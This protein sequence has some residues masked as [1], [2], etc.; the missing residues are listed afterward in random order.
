MITAHMPG[1]RTILSKKVIVKIWTKRKKQC[2][3]A[4]YENEK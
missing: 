1:T 4:G 2:R 3:I